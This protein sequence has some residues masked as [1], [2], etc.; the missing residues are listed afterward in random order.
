MIIR[1]YYPSD[2]ETLARLFYNTVH[3]INQKDY[4]DERLNAWAPENIDI[5]KWKLSFSEHF[6]LVAVKDGVVAGFG[7]VDESGLLDRLYT[8]KDY[9]SMGVASAICDRL[10]RRFNVRKITTHASITAKPFFIRR[11]YKVIKE[12]RVVRA[13]V[14]LTNYLMEKEF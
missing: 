6:T 2:T 12:R 7:D 13:G 11:G 9:Q 14:A 3:S 10:E 8:H 4:N 5:E 1:N